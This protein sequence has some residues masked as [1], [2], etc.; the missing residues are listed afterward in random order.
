MSMIYCI[1]NGGNDMTNSQ[2]EP[3]P[4]SIKMISIVKKYPGILVHLLYQTLTLV[5][6]PRRNMPDELLDSE[7]SQ[8]TLGISEL[9]GFLRP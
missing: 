6:L 2:Q 5:I 4:Q 3:S 8:V 9:Q 1:V 7:W